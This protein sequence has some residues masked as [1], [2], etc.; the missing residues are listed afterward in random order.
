MRMDH[1]RL[2]SLVS[3]VVLLLVVQVLLPQPSS[4]SERSA[5]PSSLTRNPSNG[6]SSVGPASAP[7]Y[8]GR[9]PIASATRGWVE[10]ISGNPSANGPRS[11]L[12]AVGGVQST[13][14]LKNDTLV[15][16]VDL[17]PNGVN[18]NA[19]AFDARDDLVFVHGWSSCDV[20]VINGSTGG[21]ERAIWGYCVVYSLAYDSTDGLLF[22]I[23]GL[24]SVLAINVTT[25]QT[26]GEV[27]VG[28]LPGASV[29][30]PMNDELYVGNQYSNTVTAIDCATLTV[31]ATIRVGSYPATIAYDPV[32][33]DLYVGNLRSGNVTV[34]NTTTNRVLT[35][36]AINA[37][38]LTVDPYTGDIFIDTSLAQP[39]Y[40]KVEVL[41]GSSNVQVNWFAINSTLLITFGPANG[42]LYALGNPEGGS[43]NANNLNLTAINASSGAIIASAPAG[44]DPATATYDSVDKEFYV[45]DGTPDR[46]TLIDAATTT[47]V[48]SFRLGTEPTD[49]AYDPPVQKLFVADVI[50][51]TVTVLNASTGAYEGNFSVGNTTQG[52]GLQSIAVD[53][54]NGALYAAYGTNI[55]VINATDDAVVTTLELSSAPYTISWSPV[56]DDLYAADSVR[57]VTIVNCVTNTVVGVV[58]KLEGPS[59][60]AVSSISRDLYIA[61][62][63]NTVVNGSTDK[64]LATLAAGSWPVALTWDPDNGY[65]YSVGSND[66]I[67]VINTSSNL[68][69]GSIGASGSADSILAD[70]TN[71]DLY[72]SNA[73]T[74]NLSVIDG[75]SD[76]VIGSI[77]VG[78]YPVN[79]TWVG[80]G[81]RVLV[82]NRAGGTVATVLPAPTTPI[83]FNESGLPTGASWA[84]RQGT[85]VV[86]S[87][88]ASLQLNETNGSY[89]FRIGPVP[90][91]SP[92]PS[93]V[94]L[95]VTGTSQY[96]NVTF[97]P[98]TDYSV[99]FVVSGLLSGAQWTVFWN[100]SEIVTTRS[101][102]SLEAPNGSYPYLVHGPAG[103]VVSGTAAVGTL[104]VRGAAVRL[105]VPF[106]RGTALTVRF[107]EA[108]LGKGQVWCVD[109]TGWTGC[110][111]SSAVQ[112]RNLTA[113]TYNYSVMAP[114]TGL[115][116][117]ARWA[118]RTVPLSTPVDLV[119][120]SAVALTF[121]YPFAVVFTE[122]GLPNGT[123]WSITVQGIKHS[124]TTDTINFSEPN[125]TYSFRIGAET[126]YSHAGSPTSVKVT[127]GPV[128]VTV[129]FRAKPSRGPVAPTVLSVVRRRT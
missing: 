114:L 37:F 66:W 11:L 18:P 22:E 57:N 117:T 7:S 1:L 102:V 103:Y 30:D 92:T 73:W 76:Q 26:V 82:A 77:P 48:G 87:T 126:G 112:F 101:N 127:G 9:S 45:A 67:S 98:V 60:V 54:Q 122:T 29:W 49:V 36:L 85:T 121:H 86:R 115:T 70:P 88:G 32:N 61:T 113:G 97:T 55:S 12:D 46:L 123:E 68:V 64:V 23:L 90:G 108:G 65:V 41:N 14:V 93:L 47:T 58:Q 96:V 111:G 95:P 50:S 39:P 24:G 56:T 129:T 34:I 104:M 25:G 63:G 35:S 42:Y 19:M 6:P 128:N 4:S 105:L 10:A 59:A 74:G 124:S 89:V 71:G 13:F 27:V 62:N 2:W 44:D 38:Y 8:L 79:A 15:N 110:S 109:L 33:R 21:I 99:S 84:V 118:G 119:H 51:S 100:G 94:S 106:V 81:D 52:D 16:G 17:A 78:Y 31:A 28:Q 20:L 40:E 75:S 69:V 125:G 120:S 83:T 43:T 91:Y 107:T 5:A 53:S 3:V 72:V 80:A 116:I